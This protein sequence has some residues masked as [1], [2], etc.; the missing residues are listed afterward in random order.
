MDDYEATIYATA[1]FVSSDD[2]ESSGDAVRVIAQT[3]TMWSDYIFQAPMGTLVGLQQTIDN[4]NIVYNEVFTGKNVWDTVGWRWHDT[5]DDKTVWADSDYITH[6]SGYQSHLGSVTLNGDS[7]RSYDVWFN[8]SDDCVTDTR[9][10]TFF[11]PQN[12]L[13]SVFKERAFLK[14]RRFLFDIDL[15]MDADGYITPTS[16][17]DLSPEAEPYLKVVAYTEPNQDIV[18]QDDQED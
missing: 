7:L 6:W 15:Q 14:D 12:K 3:S 4:Q 9:S 1:V 13:H 5:S 18:S 10:A 17:E 16:I 8:D 2:S 11:K